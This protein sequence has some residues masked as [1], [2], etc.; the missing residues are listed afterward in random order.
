MTSYSVVAPIILARFQGNTSIF[1]RAWSPRRYGP[2]YQYDIII[3]GEDNQHPMM[4]IE[5][6]DFLHRVCDQLSLDNSHDDDENDLLLGRRFLDMTTDY[7]STTPLD[8]RGDE[9]FVVIMRE[10]VIFSPI[11]FL[12]ED[13]ELYLRFLENEFVT[14]RPHLRILEI[15]HATI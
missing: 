4:N 6:I 3:E 2:I 15:P 11:F 1:F 5:Y 12:R 7:H 10:S 9:C 13:V 14:L 8:E